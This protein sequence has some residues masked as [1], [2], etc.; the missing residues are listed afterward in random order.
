M[1]NR[2]AIRTQLEQ[3]LATHCPGPAWWRAEID[4]EA[5]LDTFTDFVLSLT[6][7]VTE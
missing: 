4:G 3:W 7:K 5:L 1:A 6:R 2:Q